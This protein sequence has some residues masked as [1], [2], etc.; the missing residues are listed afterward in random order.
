MIG[1]PRCM[2]GQNMTDDE[3]KAQ[4]ALISGAA[5]ATDHFTEDEL[6]EAAA[7]L[8]HPKAK[9]IHDTVAKLQGWPPHDGWGN[10]CY[11]DG[12][13]AKSLEREFG[14]PTSKLISIAENYRK[15]NSLMAKARRG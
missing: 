12:Y 14:L 13:Y 4:C 11:G 15:R 7:E 8:N 10:I 1:K 9:E 6:E 5:K 2:P 3:I